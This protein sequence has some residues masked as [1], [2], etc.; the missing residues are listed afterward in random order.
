V[1]AEAVRVDAARL[2]GDL[3]ELSG[4]GRLPRG[5]IT[6]TSYSAADLQ[7]RE[8]FVSRCAA[9]GLEVRSDGLGNLL[10]RLVPPGADTSLPAVWTGSHLDTV[11][12]GGAYDGAVGVLSALECLRRLAEERV[13]LSRPVQLVM[14][15]DEEG[16]Y[17]HLLGSTGL[18]RGLSREQLAD[19][20]GRDG[21]RLVDALAAAGL[22]LD[23]A[24]STVVDPAQVHA[25]VELHIEQ[26]PVLESAGI[27]IGVVTSIVGMGGATVRFTGRADHAGT[28]PMPARHDALRAAGHF[29]MRLPDV[30]A[31][32]SEQA[33]C[34]C[35]LIDVTPGAT[36]VVPATAELQLDYRDISMPRM[37]ALGD[38][39]VQSAEAA[40]GECS[41]AVDVRFEDAVEPVLLDDGVQD[42]VEQAAASLGYSSRRMPSGAG[43]DAQ[44]MAKIAR[45]GMIFVPSVEGRSHA[46]E[47]YTSPEDIER[48]ANVLLVTLIR[49]CSGD[50]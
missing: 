48:G 39:I 15:A 24:A 17:H 16:C 31:A 36:N 34:T 28:T 43:H 14:F 40:A 29:L 18:A 5:G 27:E 44:N 38:G 13:A 33:V 49:L 47:E 10:A 35:G 26:G 6:R 21:A 46:K 19:R 22:D 25:Y 32:V 1:T 8:W 37:L 12:E 2:T 42:A 11:P 7:A 41:V 4:F 45:A 20:H 3:R 9:A 30:A 23:G 50:R